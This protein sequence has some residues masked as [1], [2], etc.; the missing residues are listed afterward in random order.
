MPDVLMRHVSDGGEVSIENGTVLLQDGLETAVYLSL[1][2]GEERDRGTPATDAATW[3]GN[4][5][6][7]DAARRYRGETHYLLRHAPITSSTRVAV[8]AAAARDLAWL[9][10]AYASRVT[11]TATIPAVNSIRLVVEVLVDGHLRTF[12]FEEK[13][14]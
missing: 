5:G 14:A 9:L 6:E 13:R 12:T 11:T 10:P 8:E 7:A 1:F 2:G 3:W 4:R